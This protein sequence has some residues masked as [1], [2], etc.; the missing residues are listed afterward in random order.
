MS[1]LVFGA[2]AYQSGINRI[3]RA[4]NRELSTGAP[5]ILGK[6]TGGVEMNAGVSAM[7]SY[8]NITQGNRK[9]SKMFGELGKMA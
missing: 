4:Q 8:V 9:L 3:A 1:L 6:A 5:S 7:E 2:N